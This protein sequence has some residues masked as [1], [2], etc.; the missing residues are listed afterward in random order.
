MVFICAFKSSHSSLSC[1][2]TFTKGER[3]EIKGLVLP[4]F[5][6]TFTW[7]TCRM[8]TSQA[9][10]LYQTILHVFRFQKLPSSETGCSKLVTPNPGE[11]SCRAP[12]EKG[13]PSQPSLL[14]LLPLLSS[15]KSICCQTVK[16]QNQHWL[17]L[18]LTI[19]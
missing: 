7:F 19:T 18:A 8:D 5:Q 3:T 11:R 12:S 17:H 9:S 13:A 4:L 16:K 1:L 15:K 6:T 14:A 10:P 2:K